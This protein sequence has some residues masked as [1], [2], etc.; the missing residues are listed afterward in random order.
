MKKFF[1]FFVLVY[2]F[3]C[4]KNS[5]NK[6]VGRIEN[7][8]LADTIFVTYHPG[9]Y[10]PPIR[11]Y[12]SEYISI[13]KDLTIYEVIMIDKRD[14]DVIVSFIKGPHKRIEIDSIEDYHC[15]PEL[16]IQVGD[17][18]VA[19]GHPFY[20]F[21]YYFSDTANIYIE[22]GAEI[23]YRIRNLSHYYNC[24]ELNDVLDDRL[25]RT[26]GFPKYYHFF[27]KKASITIEDRQDVVI[28]DAEDERETGFRKVA[29]ICK[30]E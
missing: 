3:A 7:G 13:A 24:Q 26:Y 21:D 15:D 30:K 25:V 18:C 2:L 9:F 19:M 28:V 6:V 4:N 5:E 16:L 8:I 29:L 23:A 27:K 20:N 1:V 14:Y 10:L 17:S 12:C 11:E 22:G